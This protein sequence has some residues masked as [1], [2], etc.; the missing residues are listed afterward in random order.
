MMVFYIVLFSLMYAYGAVIVNIQPLINTNFTCY[1]I[2][3]PR[4]YSTY[5]TSF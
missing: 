5:H 3:T 1:D 4:N 2:H